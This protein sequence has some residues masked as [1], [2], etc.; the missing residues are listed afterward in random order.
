MVS[1]RMIES[2]IE[3]GHMLIE[4]A[5]EYKMGKEMEVHNEWSVGQIIK[6]SKLSSILLLTSILLC[7]DE[8]KDLLQPLC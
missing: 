4:R 7:C 2:I 3:N 6:N 1:L 5:T 8:R